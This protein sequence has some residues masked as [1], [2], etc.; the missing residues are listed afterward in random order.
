MERLVEH[1]RKTS[2]EA[3][4]VTPWKKSAGSLVFE[5][6]NPVE[7]GELHSGI[8]SR[9][10]DKKRSDHLEARLGYSSKGFRPESSVKTMVSIE[11]KTKKGLALLKKIV[12]ALKEKKHVVREL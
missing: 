5:C 7:A 1:I 12:S 3:V 8:A 4:F 6:R 2:S 9:I 11:P 10:F